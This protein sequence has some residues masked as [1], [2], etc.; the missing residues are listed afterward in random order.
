[1]SCMIRKTI[2]IVSVRIDE[3]E[4]TTKEEGKLKEDCVVII[5]N[6]VDNDGE[7]S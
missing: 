3:G 6:D 4:G 7:K 1:M 2:V 5:F